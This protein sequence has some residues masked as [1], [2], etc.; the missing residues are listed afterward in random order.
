[1][2]DAAT[3]IWSRVRCASMRSAVVL[4]LALLAGCVAPGAERAGDSAEDARLLLPSILPPVSVDATRWSGEPSILALSDGTLLI[5]GAGGLSRYA[6]DPLD[7]PGNFGQSYLWRSTDAGASWSFVDLGAPAPVGMLAPYRNGVAGVEGDLAQDEAGRAYFVD[8]AALAANGLSASDDS[9]ATWTAVQNPAV[10]QPGTDRPWVA[11]YGEGIV[12]VKY[13]AESGSHRVARS[14]DGGM[15][16]LEDVALPSCGQGALVADVPSRTIVV[17]CANGDELSF[18]RTAEGTMAWEQV[19]L[20]QAEGDAS[21]VFVSMA[22]AQPGH[23]VFA[24]SETTETGARLR[25]ASSVDAGETWSEPITLSAPGHTAVFPWVDANVDGVVGVVWYEA[26]AEGKP[27][28]IDANWLPMHASMRLDPATAALTAPA[29]SPLTTDPVHV[30]A[31]CTAGLGCVLD[32]RAEDRRLLDFFE[33]DVDPAGRS[34]VTW[35]NTQTDVPT[36]WY[37]AALPRD[38]A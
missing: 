6:E 38:V 32:G 19:D 24:Y 22:V 9:G 13:L 23:Y 28:T 5:T 15:T 8:L 35:T 17:P 3:L 25:V 29:V 33:I 21:N 26:D 1:M 30:G 31:I 4:V 27:D 11:A 34:H 12:Y 18:L 2:R 37:G 16:F 20:F 14:T 10:G 36:I 7:I